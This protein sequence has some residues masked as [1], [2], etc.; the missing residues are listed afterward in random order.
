M[1]NCELDK[2]QPLCQGSGTNNCHEKKTFGED[3]D[4][5]MHKRRTGFSRREIAKQKRRDKNNG[6]F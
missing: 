3:Y 6:N 1:L 5:L 2:C 4:T